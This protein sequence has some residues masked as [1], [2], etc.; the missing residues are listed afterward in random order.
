M[1][2]TPGPFTTP[3]NSWPVVISTTITGYAVSNFDT[4]VSQT[5]SPDRYRSDLEALRDCLDDARR[6]LKAESHRPPPVA[7]A[8]A[9]LPEPQRSR[10]IIREIFREPPRLA[11]RLAGTRSRVP[12]RSRPGFHA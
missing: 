8:L 7:V 6:W 9:S 11:H 1:Y 2:A 12:V 5:I 4:C 3:T 10:Q